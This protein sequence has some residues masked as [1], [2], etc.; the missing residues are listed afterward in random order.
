MLLS[1][2]ADAQSADAQ[3]SESIEFKVNHRA[4][5]R[6][7][8]A[9]QYILG[10]LYQN[11]EGVR[12][13]YAKAAKWFKKA[14][15]QGDARAQNNLGLLYAEGR[16]VPKDDA[17]AAEWLRKAAEGGVSSRDQGSGIR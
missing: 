9:A 7:D 17:K 15:E 4:A 13:D 2:N 6:G 12:K 5:M 3:T 1:L 14:A 8:A 10:V 16:G 11:G